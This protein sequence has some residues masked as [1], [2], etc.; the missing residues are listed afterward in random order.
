LT[1]C[2]ILEDVRLTS[3]PA[4]IAVN[5]HPLS[6]PEIDVLAKNRR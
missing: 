2:T 6:M 1:A 3:E 4:A 5:S